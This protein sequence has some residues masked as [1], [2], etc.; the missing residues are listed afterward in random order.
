MA[1]PTLQL[2]AARLIAWGRGR[3][4]I[5]RFAEHP[6]TVL[7][8][9]R[10]ATVA[11]LL[12]GGLLSTGALEQERGVIVARG[13]PRWAFGRGGTTIGA[14]YLTRDNDSCGVLDHEAVHRAQ[15][16]RY[17]LAMIP[18]YLAAGPVATENRFEQEAGLERGGYR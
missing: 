9:Y 14:V 15:W 16:R 13:C 1:A 4:R 18:L 12:W 10:V 5:A 6:L 17:G 2:L 3:P 7:A 8:G 11:G